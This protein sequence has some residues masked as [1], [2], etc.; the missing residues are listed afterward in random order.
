MAGFAWRVAQVLSIAYPHRG[1]LS[2]LSYEMSKWCCRFMVGFHFSAGRQQVLPQ[3]HRPA[4]LKLHSYP[5]SEPSSQFPSA[6]SPSSALY[7][8]YSYVCSSKQ[9]LDTV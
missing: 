2:V 5:W 6:F 3:E 1:S 4:K 7:P 9:L 8:S